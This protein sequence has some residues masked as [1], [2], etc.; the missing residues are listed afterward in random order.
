MKSKNAI[1][2]GFSTMVRTQKLGIEG[3]GQTK[4]EWESFQPSK[5]GSVNAVGSLFVPF[6]E[7]SCKKI[8]VS[9]DVAVEYTEDDLL[10][11]KITWDRIVIFKK[12]LDESK[13]I[14]DLTT[15]EHM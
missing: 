2:P 6:E 14:T 12:F 7:K 5:V 4:V 10:R 8:N 3:L 11:T 15:S 1:L 9:G 13:N